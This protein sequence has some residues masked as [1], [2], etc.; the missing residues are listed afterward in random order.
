MV[1]FSHFIENKTHKP[2]PIKNKI[3]IQVF[4]K[5]LLKK[6]IPDCRQTPEFG[7]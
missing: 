5:R 4:L 2:T 7:V 1:L 3:S 6:V